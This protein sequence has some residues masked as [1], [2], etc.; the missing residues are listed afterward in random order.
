MY[1]FLFILLKV[2]FVRFILFV[3]HSCNL[4]FNAVSNSKRGKTNGVES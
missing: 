1:I 4:M 2:M 3:A